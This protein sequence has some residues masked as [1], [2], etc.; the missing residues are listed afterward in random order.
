MQLD[1]FS[2]LDIVRIMSISYYYGAHFNSANSDIY[3]H[4]FYN[5]TEP[6][7][8]SFLISS[9]YCEEPLK[10]VPSLVKSLF[11]KYVYANIPLSKTINDALL[12]VVSK[13][14]YNQTPALVMIIIKHCIWEYL[15]NDKV[16]LARLISQYMMIARVFLGV[17]YLNM[18]NAVLIHVINSLNESE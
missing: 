3:T 9:D 6:F 17:V 13:A 18:I 2:T 12:N 4:D 15:N 5:Y 14:D 7:L 16:A 1:N 10:E 11:M 8:R